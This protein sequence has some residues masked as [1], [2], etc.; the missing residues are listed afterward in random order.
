MKNEK[1]I[2]NYCVA[3]IDLCCVGEIKYADIYRAVKL[4]ADVSPFLFNR[5]Q[6][7]DILKKLYSVND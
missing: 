1:K 2:M 3:L 6:I 7:E 4:A 5:K